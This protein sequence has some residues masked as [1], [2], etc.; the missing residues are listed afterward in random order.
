[1]TS[2][3]RFFDAHCDTIQKVVGNGA[4]FAAPEGMHVTLPGM[5]KAGMCAQVFAAWALAERLRGREDEVAM[6]MVEAVGSLC[7]EHPDRLVLVRTWSDIEA[8]CAGSGKI[9]AI[10]GL[11][12]ADPLKGDPQALLPF[13]HAGVRLLTLAWADNAFS[14]TAVNPYSRTGRGTGLGLTRKGRELVGVCD[15]LGVVVD[16]S[17]ASDQAFWDVCAV[18]TKPFV[19]SHSN[20]RALCPHPRN[21]TDEMIRAVADRG[22]VVGINL[23]SGFLSPTFLV[24]EQDYSERALSAVRAGERTLEEAEGAVSAFLVA[25]P[26]PP[27]RLLADHVKHIVHVGGEDCVGLG[28]DLDGVDST[29]AEIDGVADYPKIAELL[30]RAGMTPTQ[31]EKVCHRNFLRVFRDVLGAEDPL[32]TRPTGNASAS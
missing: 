25:I 4:D 1:V 26:R 6:R 29:P 10:C 28:G 31:V 13:Y 21:L 5:L 32:V 20:C 24:Q 19:A 16:V 2:R 11:E 27:L 17:H 30:G 14:G 8:A 22:G 7:S 12:G 3:P 23:F 15:E 9:A 18:S